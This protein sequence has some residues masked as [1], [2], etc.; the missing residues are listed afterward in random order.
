MHLSRRRAV[1]FAAGV[2][3]TTVAVLAQQQTPAPTPSST[4]TALVIDGFAR[5][6]EGRVDD[7]RAL[8]DRAIALS[9]ANDLRRIEAEAHRGMGRVLAEKGDF[10]ASREAL[11][12]SLAMFEA[13]GE[14]AGIGQVWNQIGTTAY[15]R[16]KWDEAE[17]AYRKS[18]AAF[19][20]AG[21][22]R[23]LANALRNLTFLPTIAIDERLRLI[24]DATQR[25]AS[26]KDFNVQGAALHQ[27]GDLLV[28]AT[29]YAGAMQKL[30]ASRALLEAHGTAAQLAR[31]YTS[32][33]R[34]YR[35]HGEPESALPYYEKALERERASRD[36]AGQVQTLN[37]MALAQ[38]VLRRTRDADA[39]HTQALAIAKEGAT[40]QVPFI[41][42]QMAI[43]YT[44]T[45]RS[46]RGAELLEAALKDD[47][48]TA[49]RVHVLS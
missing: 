1:A 36:V 22:S 30:E 32:I 49:E 31:L 14:P 43:F 2:A 34:I 6:S 12:R 13:I 24:A 5:L 8:F 26:V 44:E 35:L 23:D 27:W 20:K 16:Q 42:R 29:D 19:E 37:A 33:G 9:R 25:A 47:L 41:Q 28:L 45:G 39:S 10:T 3:L 15:M 18:A 17:S 4:A 38:H 40:A 11:D 46:A 48:T 7:A 21:A